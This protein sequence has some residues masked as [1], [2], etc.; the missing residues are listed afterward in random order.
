MDTSGCSKRYVTSFD[1][2]EK[3]YKNIANYGLKPMETAKVGRNGEYYGVEIEAVDNILPLFTT[4]NIQKAYDFFLK[5]KIQEII[6]L[7]KIENE[8]KKYGDDVIHYIIFKWCEHVHVAIPKNINDVK[9]T[10]DELEKR[11][12]SNRSNAINGKFKIIGIGKNSNTGEPVLPE[13]WLGKIFD[14]GDKLHEEMNKLPHRKGKPPVTYCCT[15]GMSITSNNEFVQWEK[16]I[17]KKQINKYDYL[18][19]LKKN[20]DG[21][22][23]EILFAGADNIDDVL[24]SKKV[25]ELVHLQKSLK[26]INGIFLIEQGIFVKNKKYKSNENTS[27]LSSLLQKC[28]RNERMGSLLSETITKLHLSPGYNL[29]DQHFARVSGDRQLC[30]R[31]YI[32]IIEDVTGYSTQHVDLLDLFFMAYVCHIDPNINLNDN[33]ISRIK[34][35]M[36]QVQRLENAWNWRKYKDNFKD[37]PY[38][39]ILKKLKKTK[40]NVLN[41]GKS[42]IQ[43]SVI[44]ALITMPMMRNDFSMISKCYDLLESEDVPKLVNSSNEIQFEDDEED[45]L[46][47]KMR[48]L[49]M[50]CF[51]YILIQLQGSLPFIPS[52][53]ETLHD[54]SHFIWNNSSKFNTR[55]DYRYDLPNKNSIFI[56]RSLLD[57]QYISIQKPQFNIKFNWIVTDWKPQKILEN[58][59]DIDE[60]TK[61]L[62]F[63]M[64]FGK[65]EK[66]NKKI[67]NKQYDAVIAGTIDKPCKIKRTINRNKVEFVDG[68]ERFLAEKELISQ[69]Q[70]EK[71]TIDLK[72]ISPPLGFKWKKLFKGNIN[73]KIV[74]CKEKSESNDLVFSL[75][76]IKM[77]PFDAGNL[78][79]PIE[80]YKNDELPDEFKE[81]LDIAFYNEFGE[82]FETLLLL[83]EIAKIRYENGDFRVFEWKALAEQ[84]PKKIILYVKAK[85]LMSMNEI[86]IGP[87][88]RRGQKTQNS[89][90]YQYEGVIW[91]LLIV[92]SALYPN[93]I[94]IVTPYKFSLNRA[95]YGYINLINTLNELSIT[96]NTF[97]YS[98]LKNNP[99]IL[100]K[101]WEHQEKSIER[102]FDGMT[103]Q[104]RRGFGDASDVGS[105]KTLTALGLFVKL[106]EYCKMRKINIPNKGC[107]IMVPTENLY[108]TWTSEIKKH[109][110]GLNI[111]TQ[112]SNGSLNFCDDNNS[113]NETSVVITTMGRCRD[114]PIIYPW[115]LV[116]I[117]ECLTVQNKEALQTEE[118][119]RQS[120]YSY[121]GI[122]MLSATFFRSR[123]EKMLYMLSMLNTQLPTTSEYLDAIL[124]ESIVCNLNKNERKW[125]VTVRHTELTKEKKT[126][127]NKIAL[128]YKEIGFEKTYQYLTKFIRTNINYVD[129]FED[130]VN[131]I[132]KL[133]PKSRILIYAN[134]KDEADKISELIKNVGRYPEKKTHVVLSYSEGTFGLNNLTEYDTILS[135]PPDP[136][137]LPQIKGRLDRP[138]QKSNI[139]HIEYILLKDTIEE[140]GL[141]K[142]EIA[143]NFYKQHII[144]LAEF[145][146]IKLIN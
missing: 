135:R 30:W 56:L 124:S 126:E 10:D 146:Q 72:Q 47:T 1:E 139:L 49:D 97:D 87:V 138:G 38:S 75:D 114:H 8:Y 113:I 81:V 104:G 76:D 102:I 55:I 26:F 69:F 11:I 122:V 127:Y 119:W 33:I 130:S 50:H 66:I 137:K 78:L 15:Y 92:F 90:N 32:S 121:F 45:K 136:D 44:F 53:N 51:P 52:K 6:N 108:E 94:K 80:K 96:K 16:L 3:P 48:A 109:I 63:L 23:S 85:I 116:V 2:N 141:Y 98:Q 134:S 31:S 60:Y 100:S 103:Q 93:T 4:D 41:D 120:I 27:Y 125:I 5:E 25:Y 86:T 91:R 34:S 36:I 18:F 21:C 54:L 57:I 14:S 12:K 68:T 79:D 143:R 99:I 65:R 40:N 112:T 83:F 142:L 28:F 35:T 62:A 59:T 39:D 37:L 67:K 110:K 9:L 61:R 118:A 111:C 145:Y 117:D 107:L 74:K 13:E 128:K 131:Q 106:I 77:L 88:D 22:K 29:P 133:R 144:P 58:K 20:N 132:T 70:T 140:A 19:V 46:E 42:R 17:N 123:F 64:L 7:L 82:I 43:N 105:G 95:T 101:L 24:S 84:L 129:I 115:L 73:I 89:V 71:K